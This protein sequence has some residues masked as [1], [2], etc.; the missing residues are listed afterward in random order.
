MFNDRTS[1]IEKSKRRSFLKATAATI[2][3]AVVPTTVAGKNTPRPVG[4]KGNKRRPVKRKHIENARA[5]VLESKTDWSQNAGKAAVNGR[6]IPEDGYLAGYAIAV[7]NGAP[8]EVIHRVSEP[9]SWE[10]V[11]KERISVDEMA[12]PPQ[13]KR[14]GGR[15]M[16]ESR[17]QGKGHARSGG[18]KV[19][20]TPPG[21]R[22]Q[23][24]ENAHKTIDEFLAEKGGK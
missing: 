9:Q 4:L 5:E 15:R 20:S 23:Q 12:R 6:P 14:P 8:V 16:K 3:T 13:A 7:E 22:K 24:E 19:Q 17:N 11:R 21:I 1:G 10:N 2:G 18:V